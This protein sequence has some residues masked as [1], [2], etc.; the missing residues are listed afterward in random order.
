MK[1]VRLVSCMSALAL[2]LSAS[3]VRA[4]DESQFK[5]E[6][7]GFVVGSLYIQNQT[8][9][10]GAGQANLVASPTLANTAPGSFLGG[11]IRESRFAFSLT[12]PKGAFIGGTPRAYFEFDLFGFA[13]DAALF[14]QYNPRMRAGIAE[15]KW[16]NTVLQGG[17]QNQLVVAQ[18]PTSVSHIPNPVTFGDGTIGWRT[19][20]VR[21]IQVVPTPAAK[22][23]LAAEIVQDK[24]GNDRVPGAAPSTVGSGPASNIPMIQARVKADGKSSGLAY[25]AYLVGD[26]HKVDLKGFGNSNQLAPTVTLAD[27]SAVP[28]KISGYAVEAGGKVVFAPVTLALN[29]YVGKATGNM[30][31]AINQFGEIKNWALWAQLG[32]DVTK[33]FSAWALYGTDHP[34]ENDVRKWSSA[35]LGGSAAANR[36][37]NQVVGGM[38]RY[39]EGGYAVALEGYQIKTKFGT[40]TFAAPTSVETKAN[41]FIGSLGYFF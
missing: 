37:K 23:E 29:A 4:A 30:L 39:L 18:V 31:G 22:L 3:A 34:K 1:T 27:G 16:E 25:T 41:Q 12:G 32:V 17:Q 13:P 38:L 2:L 24:W 14:E 11:D 8:F 10:G 15:V 20:G 7:H 26:Y 36:L 33:E 35:A 9:L 28:D 40:G 19:P 6:F 21:V 5:F